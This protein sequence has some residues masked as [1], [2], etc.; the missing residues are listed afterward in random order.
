MKEKWEL[1]TFFNFGLAIKLPSWKH[2][3][4]H[5]YIT[6]YIIFLRMRSLEDIEPLHIVMYDDKWKVMQ[7]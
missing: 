4:I 5:I 2:Y 3:P 7:I 1:E 6:E